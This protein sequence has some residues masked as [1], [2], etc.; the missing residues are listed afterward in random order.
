LSRRIVLSL[1]LV[2][3]VLLLGWF[4]YRFFMKAVFTD[5]FRAN[6]SKKEVAKMLQVDD[7][8][9]QEVGRV[10]SDLL[11]TP[12]NFA[13]LAGKNVYIVERYLN[14]GDEADRAYVRIGPGVPLE[15]SD[16]KAKEDLENAYQNLG[17][18]GEVVSRHEVSLYKDDKLLKTDWYYKVVYEAGT[19]ERHLSF[20]S[21]DRKKINFFH[22]GFDRLL[23]H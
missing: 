1:T 13:Y 22:N 9:L 17:Q 10:E 11:N 4:G 23:V 19:G 12:K 16:G 20:V 3:V 8:I 18:P 5:E 2:A 14:L 21:A 6:P 15:D 7:A